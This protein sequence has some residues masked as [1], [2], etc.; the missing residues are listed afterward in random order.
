MKGIL[1]SNALLWND[2]L[3]VIYEHHRITW[4][5]LTFVYWILPKLQNND[6]KFFYSLLLIDQ[7]DH[8][9]IPN[10]SYTYQMKQKMQKYFAV[11]YVILQEFHQIVFAHQLQ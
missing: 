5:S 2:S 9:K 6:L 7:T 10:G 8:I 3:V 1:M 11:K 4:V